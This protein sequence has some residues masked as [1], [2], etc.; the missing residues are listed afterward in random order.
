[1]TRPQFGPGGQRGEFEVGTPA[2]RH[3]L[4]DVGALRAQNEARLNDVT[5]HVQVVR[6]RVGDVGGLPVHDPRNLADRTG[7]ARR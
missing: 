7:E 4:D 2:N 1:V 3:G 6:E 5:N